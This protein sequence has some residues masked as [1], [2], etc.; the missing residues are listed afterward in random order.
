M[1][2]GLYINLDKRPDRRL[3]MEQEFARFG[4]SE[5]YK[6][7]R[8]IADTIPKMG[9]YRS[10]LKAL[11]G[12]R[13]IGGIVHILEDDSILSSA[14]V[15]FLESD[16]AIAVLDRY[17]ILFLD[18]WVD[19][20]KDKVDLYQSVVDSGQ[21][22]MPLTGDNVRIGSMSSYV[23]APNRF[24]KIRR[25]WRRCIDDRRPIDDICNKLAKEG[26]LTAAVTV[27]FLTGVDLNHGTSSNIQTIPRAE[28]GRLVML[29]TRFFADRKRQPFL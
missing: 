27:P 11:D 4:V 14:L 5:R 7:I 1:F 26:T 25:L 20:R 10:H 8:A 12:A 15:P 9:C 2:S 28:Q 16:E 3:H 23:I 24:G 21:K 17:D 29:R 18:M 22:V 6:R 13:Q 19:A